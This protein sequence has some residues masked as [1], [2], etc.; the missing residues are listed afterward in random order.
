LLYRLL[1][2]L[3][4]E[5][6]QPGADGDGRSGVYYEHGGSSGH[7]K[8][9]VPT[10][11]SGRHLTHRPHT[12]NIA[13]GHGTTDGT[14]DEMD[15]ATR[16]R[17]AKHGPHHNIASAHNQTGAAAVP[18]PM[19]AFQSGHDGHHSQIVSDRSYRSGPSVE[20]GSS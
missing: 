6:A 15:F 12:D 8:E 13:R 11:T 4:Y 17:T 18:E 1:K 7:Y 9:S 10:S 20:S 2:M 16:I 3:E 19:P 5:T 14:S